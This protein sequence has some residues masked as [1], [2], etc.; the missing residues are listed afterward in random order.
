MFHVVFCGDEKYFK[1]IAVCMTS[2]VKNINPS[3]RFDS[4]LEN[5]TDEE[6]NK[7]R[8]TFKI[9]ESIQEKYIFHIISNIVSEKTVTKIKNFESELNK[10]VP[11]EIIIHK[12]DDNIF[13]GQP[14]FRK[15]YLAYYR[16]K[17]AD[18]MPEDLETVLYL[19]GDTL[20]NCDIR[21]LF[22]VRIDKHIAATINGLAPAR[23]KLKNRTQGAPYR[24]TNA[25]YFNTGV[26]LI[27]LKEWKLHNI[28]EETL[29]FLRT[30]IG[31][32]PDQDALNAI[33]KEDVVK[34]PYK[35]NVMIHGKYPPAESI[36]MDESD[37]YNTQHTR[38]DFMEGVENPKII[39]YGRKPWQTNGFY[40]TAAL[41]P[42]YIPHFELW[43]DM[44]AQTPV[45]KQEIEDIKLSKK[46]M[47]MVKKN[48]ALEKGI[49]T[50]SFPFLLFK[51]KRNIR[52]FMAK[53]EKPFKILRNKIQGRKIK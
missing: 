14:P 50:N 52:P 13:L 23:H 4:F 32:Y 11:V 12:L 24:F 51:I 39:H 38:A 29:V 53:L 3:R 48:N 46:Y 31:K 5:M 20:V 49:E 10:I 6:K 7:I 43:W 17:L 40:I 19:D 35:W 34:I 37:R 45:F 41:K 47:D 8:S 30:Y 16:L 1:Y 44:V 18:F 2:I 27:N 25:Y 36:T 15:N 9:Q 21:E 42:Y 22:A 28:G 26:M 33:I